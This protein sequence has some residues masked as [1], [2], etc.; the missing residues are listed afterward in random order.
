MLARSDADRRP[1]P[2][3]FLRPPTCVRPRRVDS[4][5]HLLRTCPRR[6]H[7]QATGRTWRETDFPRPR[8][9]HDQATGRARPELVFP[10]P[11]LPRDQQPR[12]W[13]EI[14]PS[15]ASPAHPVID[16]S[17]RSAT[18]ACYDP[19]PNVYP[20]HDQMKKYESRT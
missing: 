6:R 7:D 18:A 4:F 11:R 17:L 3:R 2:N 13:P 5:S 9:P 12:A 10:R 16:V 19:P 20:S 1:F 8:H 15:A 14:E